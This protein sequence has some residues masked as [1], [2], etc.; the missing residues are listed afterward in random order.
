MTRLFARLLAPTLA[1]A[2]L[3]V[4]AVAQAKPA[5]PKAT[6]PKVGTTVSTMPALTWNTAKG[7]AQYEV[8][9]AQRFGLQPGARRRDDAEPALRQRQDAA[10][11]RL[12]LARALGRRGQRLVEV[13]GRAQVHEEV[14][15]AW[16]RC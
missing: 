16:R 3:F 1:A 15:R 4:P 12:L 2:V 5:A 7:A 8:Q 11:R 14:E 9:I 13:V 6:A 10:Q